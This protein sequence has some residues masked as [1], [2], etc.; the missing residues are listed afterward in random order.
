MNRYVMLALWFAAFPVFAQNSVLIVGFGGWSSCKYGLERQFI[1]KQIYH[2]VNGLRYRYPERRIA[3]LMA[4]APGIA[5]AKDNRRM[6]YIGPHGKGTYPQNAMSRLIEASKPDPDSDV[7]IIGHSHGGGTAMLAA[8]QL[9][10]L[11]GLYTL[12]PVSPQQCDVRDFIQN[13]SKRLIRARQRI[14]QGCRQ[15]PT[16][17][18]WQRI[19]QNLKGPW[20]NFILDAS[21][22][23][24]DI[25]SS[26]IANAHNISYRTAATDQFSSHHLLGLSE[27]VWTGVC[28]SITEELGPSKHEISDCAGISVNGYGL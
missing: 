1:A 17:V 8:S 26:A 14:I 11:S 5:A 21:M 16:D 27:S 3:Y 18:S 25:H 6:E 2:L 7:Y 28:R 24:S 10:H 13:R 23:R 22:D 15:A 20:I 4:C 19:T 12:E 9:S